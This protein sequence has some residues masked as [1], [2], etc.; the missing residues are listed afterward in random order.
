MPRLLRSSPA[1]RRGPPTAWAFSL[2]P[3]S[4]LGA[5]V[6]LLT[7]APGASVHA[8]DG[9]SPVP[10]RLI[11]QARAG[12]ADRL[13]QRILDEHGGALAQRRLGRSEL[14]VVQLRPGQDARALAERLARHPHIEWVEPDRRLPLMRSTNDPYLGSQWHLPQIGVPAAW[15][16]TLG[17]GITIGIVDTGVDAAHPDLAPRLLAGWNFVDANVDTSD[18]NGHGTAVAG[19]AAAAGDNGLGVAGVAGQAA[20]LPLRVAGADGMASVSAIADAIT[21]A[22][23]RGA[24]VVNVS[25]QAGG[26]SAVQ[27]AAAYLRSRGGL[28]T[29]SA[30]NSGDVDG[31]APTDTLLVVGATDAG[32]ALAGF[33]TRGAYVTLAAPGVGV[34]TTNAG[35][36]YAAWSGTSF[37]APVAAGAIGLMMAARPDLPADRI[38]S[39]LVSTS[40]DLGPTGRDDGYGAGRLNAAAAVQAALAEPGGADTQAPSAAVASPGAGASVSG[41]VAVGVDAADNVGVVK[42]ELRVNGAL[43]AT[44]TAAPWGFSWDSTALPNG[45]AVLVA[46]AYDAAGNAGPS[47]ARTVTVSNVAADTTPPVLTINNPKPGATI[48]GQVLVLASASDNA[49]MAGLRHVLSIDGV[50][51][52][53][54]TGGGFSYRWNTV[55]VAAGPHTLSVQTTDAAGNR[56]TRSVQVTK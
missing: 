4:L 35:G 39:H 43:L 19:S 16:R 33:S 54:G 14:R 49:G 9:T 26:F 38:Q 6:A 15:D 10:D 25:Y 21:W 7:L 47:A 17:A 23:E 55:R 53:S 51:V 37:S 12:L 41:L 28:V 8:Q 31:S 40:V 1:R 50:A 22:A 20:I 24:R 34:W 13:L 29:V 2:H 52:A 11:L 32:D 18:R 45:S 42:V 30:G 56:T 5:L 27:S 36:G 3:K 46:T 48:G 44:D